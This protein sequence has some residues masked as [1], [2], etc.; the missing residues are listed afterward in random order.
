MGHA[1]L[2]FQKLSGIGGAQTGKLGVSAETGFR[3][4]AVSIVAHELHRTGRVR[5]T[6]GL[7][8]EKWSDPWQSSRIRTVT[9]S[10]TRTASSSRR[11]RSSV[12]SRHRTARTRIRA[13]G[14]TI[15]AVAAADKAFT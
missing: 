8:A 14:M 2:F 11:S 6:D 3:R 12:S 9:A 1:F 15:A 13:I 10:R 5:E 4:A 7:C